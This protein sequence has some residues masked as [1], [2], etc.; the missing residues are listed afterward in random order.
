MEDEQ[1]KSAELEAMSEVPKARND[2]DDMKL[3]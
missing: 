2:N 3:E 1:D